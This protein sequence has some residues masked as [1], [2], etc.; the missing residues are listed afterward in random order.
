MEVSL[1]EMLDA[2]ER[3]AAR[4]RELLGQ[5]GQTLVCFTMN[6]AGPVKNSPLIARG[7]CLGR[8]LLRQQLA[9]AGMPVVHFE[10]IREKTGNEAIFLVA[11]QALA[12][13]AV[14][15]AIEDASP[16]G[17][18]FDMDVLEST[19]R[20]IDRQELGKPGRRCL[21]CGGMAGA[22]ARSRAHSVA[23]LQEKTTRILEE[24]LLEADSRCAA[25]LA[26]QALLYE[27]AVTPK[28]GL[29]DRENS[30]SHRDMDVFSFLASGAGLYPYFA[31]CV[32]IGRQGDTPEE[33]FRALRTPGLLAEG[34]MLS[35][36]GGVNT[37]K[38]AIF[39]MGI[40]CGAL[41]RL[42]RQDWGDADRV[43]AQCAAM[44]KGLTAGDFA[45]LTP[46]TAKTAGQKLYLRYG[47]TGVRGQ[48]EAG[49]PTVGK[50][51]LPK[52]EAALSAGKSIN[53]AGCAALVSMLADT[54]DTN[55]IHR[56]GYKLAK[57]ASEEAKVLLE[58]EPFPGVPALEKL[59]R[60]YVEKN[61]SPGGTADLLAMTLMLHFLKEEAH[62]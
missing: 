26:V 13:K 61:L 43:L 22:C 49:F 8:R 37:H 34:Q 3:R 51:G 52:L 6:I 24:A 15:T 53:E 55:M 57:A 47:I 54:V 23:Q 40:L 35:S 50:I 39:S 60:D 30:G 21:I 32:K 18:L 1:L 28:P 2:R 44:T 31:Q 11:A 9:A 7:Y 10:E 17:R 5:F 45:G 25:R 27:V 19:G 14:T 4:Q 38:G 56:G 46:E 36:T 29:V 48:A 41:G 16:V 58:Q 59:N 62:E 42:E 20:K 33:T 12:V